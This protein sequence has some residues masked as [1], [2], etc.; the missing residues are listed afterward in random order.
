M[1]GLAPF[2]AVQFAMM[3]PDGDAGIRASMKNLFPILSPH[4]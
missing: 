4:Q 2:D 3:N 1:S